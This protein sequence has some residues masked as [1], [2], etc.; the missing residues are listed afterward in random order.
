M[1]YEIRIHKIRSNLSQYL[2]PAVTELF[3]QEEA[4]D[5]AMVEDTQSVMDCLVRLHQ[6]STST[7]P[8]PQGVSWDGEEEERRGAALEAALLARWGCALNTVSPT[9]PEMVP[10]NTPWLDK[11]SKLLFREETVCAPLPEHFSPRQLDYLA[12]A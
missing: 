3:R 5:A 1:I 6:A 4:C 7:S 12:Q 2:H 10:S 8:L 9:P 11:I